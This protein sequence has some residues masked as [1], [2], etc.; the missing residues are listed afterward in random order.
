[1]ATE[2]DP[3]LVKTRKMSA[4]VLDAGRVAFTSDENGPLDV[5]VDVDVDKFE[6]LLQSRVRTLAID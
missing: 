4:E 6:S 3:T 1:V 5:C 2:I